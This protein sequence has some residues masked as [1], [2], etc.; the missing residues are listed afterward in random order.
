MLEVDAYT[1][2][3]IYENSYLSQNIKKIEYEDLYQFQVLNVGAGANF[4]SL[5]SN[6]IAGMQSVCVFPYF[7]STANGGLK[8]IESF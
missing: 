1:F 4:N 6:G 3:P 7:T 5:I 2:N 8:P